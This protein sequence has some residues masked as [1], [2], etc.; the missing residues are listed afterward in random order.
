MDWYRI[1]RIESILGIKENYDKCLATAHLR[2]DGNWKIVV[3]RCIMQ[4]AK[5]N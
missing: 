1:K 2:V 4:A 3:D 5:W